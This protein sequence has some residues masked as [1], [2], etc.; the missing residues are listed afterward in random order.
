MPTE[1][2]YRDAPLPLAEA[3]A[4]VLVGRKSRLL[5]PD[6]AACLPPDAAALLRTLVDAVPSGDEGGATGTFLA[7]ER[8]R[9][10]VVCVLPEPSS[11]HNSPARPHAIATLLGRHVPSVPQVSVLL[12]LDETTHAFAAGS[13]VA[14]AWGVYSRK[15]GP[16]KDR[17]VNVAFLAPA[18]TSVPSSVLG[19]IERAGA[20]IRLASRLV[21]TPTAELH[22]DAFVEEA[23]A[24][25]TRLGADET[26]D[27]QRTVTVT[28]I[29]GTELRDAGF[30]G[31]WGI[32]KAATRPPALVVLSHQPEGATRAI[33]WVGKGIVYDTGGL[34]L[35]GK[36]DMPGMKRDMGG[37]AAVLAAFEAAVR[38]GFPERLHAVLCLAENAIGP[39]AVR[40]DDILTMYSGKTIE[41]NNT[42]A[43]GRVVLADGVAYAVKHLA[44][45]VIV[46]LATLTGAQLV[47]TGKRHAAIVC[48]DEA[49]EVRC[50]A[51][52]R[53]SGDLVH[54]LPYAPEFF[55]SEF[56]S[57]VADLKNSVKDRMNAQSSCA[58][59]FIAE[60]LGEYTG[61]WLHVDIAG[62]AE[63]EH[64]ATGYGVALLLSLF[65]A[66]GT[67]PT[68]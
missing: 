38:G 48:N 6:V 40:N 41:V 10:V 66:D 46:D 55:R 57:D 52:G 7:S 58:A 24:V 54:P 14:R 56:K 18:G 1:I 23:R 35:K 34:S 25:A 53:H 8:P 22:T 51:A 29:R 33:A 15:S 21:E 61:A 63:A 49:L 67:S 20:G 68:A 39:E 4:L 36:T 5:A 65:G 64:R 19:A 13:A 43:E 50:I 9:R 37:A 16:A 3:D 11:R 2:E 17:K 62:P 12:C 32:G 42:D 26:A 28:V 30:G 59:Q 60:Q 44:P 45:E 31:L 27:G 47:A